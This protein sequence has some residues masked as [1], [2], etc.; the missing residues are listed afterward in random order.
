MGFL[1]TVRSSCMKGASTPRSSCRPTPAPLFR[2]STSGSARDICLLQG[3]LCLFTPGLQ[4]VSSHGTRPGSRENDG[5]GP[6]GSGG[7]PVLK[8]GDAPRGDKGRPTPH[9]KENEDSQARDQDAKGPK[10]CDQSKRQR[11]SGSDENGPEHRPQQ[12]DEGRRREI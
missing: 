1:L 7:R 11:V 6:L 3:S 2:R 8:Q 4:R 9:P 10:E 12:A 5:R